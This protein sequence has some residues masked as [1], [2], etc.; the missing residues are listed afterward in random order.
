[1]VCG[2]IPLARNA[3]AVDV[4]NAVLFFVSDLAD[5]VT[6]VSLDV[7]GGSRL[8]ALPGAGG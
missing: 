7:D 4:A 1:M 5:F 6:G 2:G 3:T 8:N